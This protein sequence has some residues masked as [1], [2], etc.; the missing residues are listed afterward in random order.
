M[1]AIF[2][3]ILD[4]MSV[5]IFF[6]KWNVFRHADHVAFVWSCYLLFVFIISEILFMLKSLCQY[7]SQTETVTGRE[8]MSSNYKD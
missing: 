1:L 4:L 2:P 5:I 8:W 3:V 7:G 6:G